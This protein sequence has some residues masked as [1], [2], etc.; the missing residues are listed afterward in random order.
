MA[1]YRISGI[2]ENDD[3]VITHYAFH[4]VL[5]NGITRA[6]KKS[7]S[8]AITLLE[9][10]GNNAVTWIWDYNKPEWIDDEK[11]IV[12]DRNSGK[13]LRTE[14]DDEL[15]DNLAHLINFDWIFK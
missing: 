15:T 6:I 12:V 11:V 2:W 10:R 1:E 3:G 7:K 9:T 4:E 13:Y 8:E 14:P 5:Q